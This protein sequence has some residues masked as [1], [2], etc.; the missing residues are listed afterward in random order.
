MKEH[1]HSEHFFSQTKCYLYTTSKHASFVRDV[2][3]A[4]DKKKYLLALEEGS[5]FTA[6]DRV[7]ASLEHV[8]CRWR[9]PTVTLIGPVVVVANAADA[10]RS[11]ATCSNVKTAEETFYTC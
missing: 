6:T 4:P 10:I 8:A 9:E 3:V 1:D 5:E 11:L 7:T 2:H